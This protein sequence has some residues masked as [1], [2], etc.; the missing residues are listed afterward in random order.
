VEWVRI[1][2]KKTQE[3]QWE[4]FDKEAKQCHGSQRPF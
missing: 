4:A 2:E 1:V 3:K